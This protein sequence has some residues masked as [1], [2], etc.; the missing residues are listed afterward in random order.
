MA[1]KETYQDCANSYYD[2]AKGERILYMSSYNEKIE[3]WR[4]RC[5]DQIKLDYKIEKN[6]EIRKRQKAIAVQLATTMKPSPSR[7]KQAMKE[8]KKFL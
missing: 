5:D 2:H 8:A 6:R 7:F 3:K 1:S 4:K